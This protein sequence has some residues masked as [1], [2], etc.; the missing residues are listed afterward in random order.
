[1]TF[2]N[3]DPS[4]LDISQGTNANQHKLPAQLKSK[5]NCKFRS[6]RITSSTFSQSSL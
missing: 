2:T 6:H 5:Q 4:S 3:V 1:M